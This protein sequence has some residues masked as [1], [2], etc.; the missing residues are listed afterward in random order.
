MLAVGSKFLIVCTSDL[1]AIVS[2]PGVLDLGLYSATFKLA[3]S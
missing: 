3:T 1:L 2:Q